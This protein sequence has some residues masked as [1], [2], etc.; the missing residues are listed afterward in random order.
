ME[1]IIAPGA[2]MVTAGLASFRGVADAG[3]VHV[4]LATGGG[5]KAAR[6]P[7]LRW[8]DTMLGNI[9]CAIVGTYRAVRKKH[10]VRTLA[11]I[12]WRVNHHIDLAAM[13]PALGRAAVATMPAPYWYLKM[14]D[15]GAQSGQSKMRYFSAL[16]S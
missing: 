2:T 11:E 12:E 3:C 13:I 10:L 6:H 8:G 14:A 4:A 15:Y 16:N 1:R 9:E 5:H 7:A